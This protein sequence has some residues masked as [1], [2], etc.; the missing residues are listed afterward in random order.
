MIKTNYHTHST[1]CDGQNTPEEMVEAAIAKNFDILGFS[2]HCLFPFSSQWHTPFKSYEKYVSEISRLKEKYSDKLTIYTGF[3][4]D[5][6]SPICCPKFDTIKQFNPDYLLGAV[7]YVPV[8]DGY[9]AADGGY[10]KVHKFITDNKIDPKEAVIRYFECE[11]EML[12]KGDFTFLAHCDLIRK[13]NSKSNPYA[14]L[15]SEEESW[16]KEQI[17]LT[18][19]EIQK[20]GVCV[21]INTGGIARG[22]L[23]SPYPSPYFLDLLHDANVPV[24]INSDS[25]ATETLDSWFPEAVEYIKKA[26]YKELTFFKSGSL[27]N[28]KI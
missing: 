12:Q 8:K 5:Y 25:H 13:Q 28:Q 21:E 1:F 15:F 6:F 18:V 4:Y 20:S 16:Y 23:D 22:Y 7:H 19:K 26:G 9:Y 27:I 24:T 17:K 14:P 10:E 2:G 3:E 11:R